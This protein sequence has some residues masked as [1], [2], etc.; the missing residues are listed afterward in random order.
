MAT[1]P[2]Y[3]KNFMQFYQLAS[4]VFCRVLTLSATVR[5]Y[6]LRPKSNTNPKAFGGGSGGLGYQASAM[7]F[8][9][10][11]SRDR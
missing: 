11:A 10:C 2:I 7:G 6:L 3:K 1:V 8:V 4:L 9:R 5:D